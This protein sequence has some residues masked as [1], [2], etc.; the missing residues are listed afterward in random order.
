MHIEE[1]ATTSLDAATTVAAAAAAALLV[2]LP[3]GGSPAFPTGA[4]R[5]TRLFCGKAASYSAGGA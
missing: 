3:L 4:R 2:F 5:V 1:A